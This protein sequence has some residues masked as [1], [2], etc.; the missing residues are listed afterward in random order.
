MN[1]TYLNSTNLE[2]LTEEEIN[3]LILESLFPT[4]TKQYK[5]YTRSKNKVKNTRQFVV[6]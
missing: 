4:E 6:R 1:V 3:E 2:S 5:Q